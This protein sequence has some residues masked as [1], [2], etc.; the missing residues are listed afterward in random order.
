VEIGLIRAN[1]KGEITSMTKI[2]T[3]LFALLIAILP[4]S[5][6]A[7]TTKSSPDHSKLPIKVQ[8]KDHYHFD[9]TLL[10]TPLASKEQCLQYLRSKNWLPLLTIS[11][12]ELVNI[13]YEEGLKEGI[14]PD[15][16]FAQSLHETGFF[17]Y[18]GDVL[19][20]QNNYSGLGTIG[21]GVKGAWFTLPRTGVRAQI[22]HLKAYATRTMPTTD[23]VDPRYKLLQ[24]TMSFGN[25]KTWQSLNGKWAVPG[26]TY[27]QT[28]LA[29]HQEIVAMP[30]IPK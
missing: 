3:I 6:L 28:I 4:V 27:G 13:F 20:I 22:Q 2:I 29:I 23:I 8:L 7:Y 26:L 10:G 21:K 15:V 24:K 19:P 16:A 17:N 12:V 30:T 9:L 11:Q 5:S 1:K 25:A 18:G 14:R